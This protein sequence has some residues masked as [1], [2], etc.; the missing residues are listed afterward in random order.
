M[1]GVISGKIKR[2]RRIMLSGTHGIGKSTW[3]ASS[4]SPIFLATEDGLSDIGV[5]RTPLLKELGQFNAWI[6]NLITQEH[7]YKTLVVD[8]IDWLE[9]LIFDYVC[10]EH[11]VGSIDE[12]NYGKGY[13]FAVKHWD[14]I[15]RG[16]DALREKKNMAIILL[17]HSRIVKVSPPDA[18][19][20]DRYEPDLHKSVSP[21]IQEWCD[22]VFFATYKINVIKHDEGFNKTR[23]MAVGCG[24]RI[25][26][27]EE[28]PTH[29]AKRRIPLPNPM[30]LDF[31]EYAKHLANGTGNVA[32][33]VNNGSSKMKVEA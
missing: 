5:D 25:M 3:A 30:P 24:D 14:F 1:I 15:L 6:S 13:G 12:I 31:A 28:G 32:G 7:E 16:L 9:K 17:S 10:L 23:G 27:T 4:P 33:V 21:M 19:T 8:T 20:Y 2:P 11:N 29:I 22:E 26:Y 18:D